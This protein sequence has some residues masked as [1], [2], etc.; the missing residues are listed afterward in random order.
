M[1]AAVAMRTGFKAGLW[2]AVLLAVWLVASL[3][4]TTMAV[5]GLATDR[6]GL[7]ALASGAP[8]LFA[9]LWERQY[10]AGLV[11]AYTAIWVLPPTLLAA[12]GYGI[13]R[14]LEEVAGLFRRKPHET[15]PASY[16]EF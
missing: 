4:G 10:G 14:L 3:A 13:Y 6:W 2:R 12:I 11:A 8:L 9:V 15:H 16:S 5:I 1:W 7:V